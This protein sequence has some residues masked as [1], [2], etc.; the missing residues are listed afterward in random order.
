MNPLHLVVPLI[1]WAGVNPGSAY[2]GIAKSRMFSGKEW[3]Q[4]EECW[5]LLAD[6]SNQ[7]TSGIGFLLP[8]EL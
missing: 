5:G 7:T 8:N 2:V 1:E 6:H 3:N 4:C